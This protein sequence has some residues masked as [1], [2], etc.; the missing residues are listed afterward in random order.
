MGK[1]AEC[2]CGRK[3]FIFGV[4]INVVGWVAV[5]ALPIMWFISAVVD[6]RALY[7]VVCPCPTSLKNISQRFSIIQIIANGIL[8]TNTPS[9]SRIF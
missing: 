4:S 6:T 5:K 9:L 8:V 3:L 1:S 2:F 7:F